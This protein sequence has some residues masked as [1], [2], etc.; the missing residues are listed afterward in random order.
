MSH[1]SLE[2][3][4]PWA[5]DPPLLPAAFDLQDERPAQ[6]HVAYWSLLHPDKGRFVA[7]AAA[8]VFH[9]SARHLAERFIAERGTRLITGISGSRIEDVRPPLMAAPP[10]PTFA[11]VTVRNMPKA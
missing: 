7:V 2:P 8:A 10:L 6:E 3:C 5:R 11:V 9:V 4:G 1:L